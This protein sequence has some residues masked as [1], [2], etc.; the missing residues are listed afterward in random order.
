M[1]DTRRRNHAD[2][3][4]LLGGSQGVCHGREAYGYTIRPQDQL[5]VSPIN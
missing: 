2:S 3:L 5:A 4:G 1:P